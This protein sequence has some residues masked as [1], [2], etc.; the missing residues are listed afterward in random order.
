MLASEN[1]ALV[2]TRPKGAFTFTV[3]RQIY[4]CKIQLFQCESMC[5]GILRKGKRFPHTNIASG[6]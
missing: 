2:V 4:M 6:S 3:V 5:S 1:N